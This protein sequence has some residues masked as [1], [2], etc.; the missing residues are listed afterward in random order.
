MRARILRNR[1]TYKM[2]DFV[3]ALSMIDNREWYVHSVPSRRRLMSWLFAARNSNHL[4]II[5]TIH[6]CFY[7]SA[8]RVQR[9][10]KVRTGKRGTKRERVSPVSLSLSLLFFVFVLS[11]C[12]APLFVSLFISPS[13]SIALYLSLSLSYFRSNC[14]APSPLLSLFIS[15]YLSLTLSIRPC[16]LPSRATRRSTPCH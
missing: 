8:S 15:S 7:K 9:N 12:L 5:V 16:L 14:L 3:G 10:K 11:S 6:I 13:P 1:S 4:F 2:I